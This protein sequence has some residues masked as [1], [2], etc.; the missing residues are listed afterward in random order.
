MNVAVLDGYDM[1]SPYIVKLIVEL[2]DLLPV[3]AP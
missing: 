1:S 2:T 3:I